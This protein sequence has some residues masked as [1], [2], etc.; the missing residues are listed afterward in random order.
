MPM[1]D[2]WRTALRRYLDSIAQD[3][4]KYSGKPATFVL[5]FGGVLSEDEEVV[6]EWGG[7]QDVFRF[8]VLDYPPLRLPGALGQAV[9]DWAIKRYNAWN[10]EDRKARAATVEGWSL[11]YHNDRWVSLP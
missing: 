10:E 5:R 4:S 3:L 1:A 11:E 6:F 2:D 9:A 8:R 7:H